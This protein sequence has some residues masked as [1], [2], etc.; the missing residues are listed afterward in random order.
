MK[1]REQLQLE[2]ELRMARSLVD[3]LGTLCVVSSS[4]IIDRLTGCLWDADEAKKLKGP[5]V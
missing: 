4:V 5:I 2:R 1:T 3:A